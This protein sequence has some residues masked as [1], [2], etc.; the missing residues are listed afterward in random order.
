MSSPRNEMSSAVIAVALADLAGVGLLVFA[1]FL[2]QRTEA[3]IERAWPAP[4]VVVGFERGDG[5]EPQT[6]PVV[7]FETTR[8][9]E[10]RFRAD[11]YVAWRDYAMGDTV[12]VLYDPQRP[13]DARVDDS[14]LL[15][16]G[17]LVA[18]AFGLIL[19][20]GSTGALGVAMISERTARRR[21][22]APIE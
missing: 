17:P 10:Q 2:Y 21:A 1:F 4:G 3:F 16:V 6:A 11:L 13:A 22:A 8:G 12:P 9:E 18:A 5:D 20:L 14:L 19:I 15:W 7:R